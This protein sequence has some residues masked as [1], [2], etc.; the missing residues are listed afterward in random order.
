MT[1]SATHAATKLTEL[2][3]RAR[4]AWA[5]Y[6]ENLVELDGVAYDEAERAEWEDLQTDL[7]EIAAERT[8]AREGADAGSA[9]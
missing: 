9:G 4:F 3:E 1:M 8:A 7:R 6:R 2:D 5:A